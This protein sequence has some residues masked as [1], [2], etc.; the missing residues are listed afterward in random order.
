MLHSD[1]MAR[2]PASELMKWQ[3]LT[4]AQTEENAPKKKPKTE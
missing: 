4:R 3:M 2:M 1:M